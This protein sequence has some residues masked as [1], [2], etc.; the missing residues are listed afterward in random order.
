MM[1]FSARDLRARAGSKR[2]S[3]TL[4]PPA[5]E[6]QPKY[7]PTVLRRWRKAEPPIEIIE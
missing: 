2:G 4:K 3:A 7:D 5:P 1:Q 6:P